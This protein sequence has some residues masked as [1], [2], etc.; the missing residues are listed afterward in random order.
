MDLAL[1]IAF[2]VVM[3]IPLTGTAVHEW[4]GI[5]IAIGVIVHLLQHT[6][7]IVTTT[8][9]IFGSCSFRNRLSYVMMMGLFAGF[10][11]IIVSG[12][13][14]SEAALPLLGVEV[15]PSDFWFWLHL[16]SVSWV[17]WLT[18]LHLALDWKWITQTVRRFAGKKRAPKRS[19]L[20]S[21]S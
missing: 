2:V 3:N 6:N 9:R 12:L 18:A 21:V 4:V 1:F 8:K 14:I 20:R 15:I 16:S 10:F 17:L 7:W 5:G 13:V 19:A 11:T